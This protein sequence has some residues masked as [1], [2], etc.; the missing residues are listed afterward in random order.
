MAPLQPQSLAGG[1]GGWPDYPFADL[2]LGI[3][4]APEILANVNQ[5]TLDTPL[6]E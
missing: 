5:I 1:A 3:T 2:A 4:Q 6:Q